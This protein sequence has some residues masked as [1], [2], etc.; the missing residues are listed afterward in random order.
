MHGLSESERPPSLEDD[1]EAE[2]AEPLSE[3]IESTSPDGYIYF[4]NKR[5]QRSSWH[6]PEGFV[7]N[8]ELVEETIE[9]EEDDPTIQ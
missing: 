4:Y 1:D 8:Y 6:K 3:W 2:G 5:S 9:Y 7:S